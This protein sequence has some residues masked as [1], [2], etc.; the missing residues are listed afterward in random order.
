MVTLKQYLADVH[1]RGLRVIEHP[2]YGGI[3]RGHMR[4]SM[5]Y[6]GRAGDINYGP[7]GAPASERAVLRWAARLADAAGLNV[8]YAYHRTHPIE[9]TN[10]NH[11]DHL[12]VDDGV[13]AAY[14]PPYPGGNNARYRQILAERPVVGGRKP[15]AIHTIRLGSVNDWAVKL[16]QQF[17]NAANG[18][19]LAVDGDFGRATERETKEW[20]RKARLTPDGVVGPKTWFRAAWGI[21]FGDKGTRVKIGQRIMGLRGSAVDGRFGRDTDKRAKQ[22][23]VYLGVEPDGD[24][25]PKT[26]SA[27]LK[28]G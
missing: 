22:V 5:H 25:G 3:S 14:R 8:I 18:S 15:H 6:K 10:N 13:I 9:R 16:W 23:Q 4:T 28:K 11:K 26:I 20:Q 1:A 21:E 24:W 27:L 2:D 17:L 7:P 19:K 12:H